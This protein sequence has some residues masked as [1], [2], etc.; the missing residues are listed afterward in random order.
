MYHY[1]DFYH[2]GLMWRTSEKG[3]PFS[4]HTLSGRLLL[5]SIIVYVYH[6]GGDNMKG[7]H[8]CMSECMYVCLCV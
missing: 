3:D 5:H 8:V 2:E 6:E 7:K 1:K 4:G